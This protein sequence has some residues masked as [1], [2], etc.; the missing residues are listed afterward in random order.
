MNGLNCGTPSLLAW[1]FLESGLDAAVAV[2]DEQT[3]AA[4][5]DL[6]NLGL[7]SGP[8]G[9]ACLSGARA[10]L[11]GHGCEMRRAMIGVGPDALVVCIN[12]EG[13]APEP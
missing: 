4:V 7:V 13:F 3:A 8:S 10:A 9:A 5:S 11:L 6:S 2:S 12:T 1:P